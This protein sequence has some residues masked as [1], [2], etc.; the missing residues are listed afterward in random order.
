MKQSHGRGENH[1]L[2]MPRVRFA[3]KSIIQFPFGTKKVSVYL[4]LSLY[5]ISSL[6]EKMVRSTGIRQ[7]VR[8]QPEN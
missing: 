1:K 4:S 2:C 6:K 3:L 8:L 7:H 5:H